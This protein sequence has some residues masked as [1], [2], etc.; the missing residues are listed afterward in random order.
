MPNILPY[1]Q[2]ARYTTRL[3][4]HHTV[5]PEL[6]VLRPSVLRIRFLLGPYRLAAN[7]R[8]DLCLQTADRL[9][10]HFVRSYRY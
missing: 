4:I 8:I 10:D 1:L 5:S 9:L 3:Q 2:I 6:I 7:H